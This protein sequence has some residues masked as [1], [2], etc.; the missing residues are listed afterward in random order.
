MIEMKNWI[1]PRKILAFDLES[2]G[3]GRE[4]GLQQFAG[5]IYINGK[6]TDELKL[7]IKIFENDKIDQKAID[8][9]GLDPK[10][11]IPPESAYKQIIDFFSKY[12]AKYDKN[13]KFT[14]LAFNGVFDLDHLNYFFEKNNDKYFGSWQNWNLID[15]L[16]YFRVM[17][18][19]RLIDLPNLKLK[20][21]CEHYGIELKAHDALSD[22]QATVKLARIFMKRVYGKG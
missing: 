1:M 17:R 16:P 21:L 6:K 14:P 11:G 7:D 4:Y 10:F 19:L 12:V 18:Y 15:P 20:D 13:D 5:I 22:I 8:V 3:I 2:S 9:H